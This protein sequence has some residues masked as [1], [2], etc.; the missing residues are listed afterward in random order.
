MAVAG[1]RGHIAFYCNSTPNPGAFVVVFLRLSLVVGGRYLE[2]GQFAA[3]VRPL[4]VYPHSP[5]RGLFLAAGVACAAIIGDVALC[6]CH[7]Y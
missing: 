6:H 7:F 1:Y 3:L 2:R 5:R 4:H